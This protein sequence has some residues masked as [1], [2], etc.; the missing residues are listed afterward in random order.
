MR[1]S[2]PTSISHLQKMV[3]CVRQALRLHTAQEETDS[4]KN[5]QAYVEMS[6]RN[7]NVWLLATD[8][9]L[10]NTLDLRIDLSLNPFSI[11]FL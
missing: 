3:G 1:L 9:V 5:K 2:F 10:C 11:K 8:A 7:T 4:V 6:K